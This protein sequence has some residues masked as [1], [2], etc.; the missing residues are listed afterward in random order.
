MQ[1]LKFISSL[2]F[3][4][5]PLCRLPRLLARPAAA[6]VRG[7]RPT[8]A[9]TRACYALLG[10]VL[11][12]GAWG[13]EQDG[14]RNYAIALAVAGSI[15]LVLRKLAPLVAMKGTVKWYNDL[16]GFGHIAVDDA[17]K[18]AAGH[19]NPLFVHYRDIVDSGPWLRE[20]ARVAFRARCGKGA[21]A[22]RCL[23]VTSIQDEPKQEPKQSGDLAT[24]VAKL[25]PAPVRERAVPAHAMPSDLLRSGWSRK[26]LAV[27]GSGDLVLPDDPAAVA[28]SLCGAL[29]AV[30]EP[31]SD[32]W[33]S[34]LA[35]LQAMV[36]RDLTGWN[37]DPGRTQDE[38][39]AAAM[40]AEE[41]LRTYT[42][43][44]GDRNA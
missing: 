29:N 5:Q 36:A 25:P 13:A 42:N 34:Y 30:F 24:T 43:I 12:L 33:K 41:R 17:Y 10:I 3:L 21:I 22:T 32:K 37:G 39:V 31:D 20:G 44:M 4:V 15:L 27:N 26:R 28:W 38:V 35:A 14:Q 19:D 8:M 2:V 23:R 1:M 11:L 40:K 9:F 18:G 7:V 6:I 16:K